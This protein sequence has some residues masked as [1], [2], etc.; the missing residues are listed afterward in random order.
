MKGKLKVIKNKNGKKIWV[1][2]VTLKNADR[3]FDLM[4]WQSCGA[5]ARFSA[6][7]QMLKEFEL[8]KGRGG[9]GAKFRL[10]RTIQNIKQAPG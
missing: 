9:S 2:K 10:R 5:E 1:R 7:W 6:S 4:F 8:L 3:D